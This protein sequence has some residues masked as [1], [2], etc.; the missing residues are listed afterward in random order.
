[1]FILSLATM[2][3]NCLQRVTEALSIRCMLLSKGTLYLVFWRECIVLKN[4][5]M[6][7]RLVA[8]SFVKA[9]TSPTSSQEMKKETFEDLVATEVEP[10]SPTLT[11]P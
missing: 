8:P 11:K 7:K 6:W 1:M 10:S 4:A 3:K 2:S 5:I 9:W